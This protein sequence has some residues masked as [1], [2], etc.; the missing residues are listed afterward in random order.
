MSVNGGPALSCC[1]EERA[2]K[3]FF[4]TYSVSLADGSSLFTLVSPALRRVSVGKKN[5]SGPGGTEH[6]DV[7]SQ[8][9]HQE[10]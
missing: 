6:S 2:G 7:E 1:N 5:E 9:T 8:E 3:F 10:S 4:L